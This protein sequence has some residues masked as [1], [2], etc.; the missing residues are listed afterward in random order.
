MEKEVVVVKFYAQM[1]PLLASPSPTHL[2]SKSFYFSGS[3]T[4]AR[5]QE[6]LTWTTAVAPSRPPQPRPF[7]PHSH[8]SQS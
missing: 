6:P 2:A 3:I 4:R 7:S 1:L 5:V 8:H